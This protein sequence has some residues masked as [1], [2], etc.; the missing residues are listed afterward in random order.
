MKWAI[1]KNN[2]FNGEDAFALCEGGK[3]GI[4]HVKED[5]STFSGHKVWK[6]CHIQLFDIGILARGYDT[7]WFIFRHEAA[8]GHFQCFCLMQRLY[9]LQMTIMSHF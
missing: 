3:I 7:Q 5:A 4:Q 8:I 6:L 1:V 2:V 9:A